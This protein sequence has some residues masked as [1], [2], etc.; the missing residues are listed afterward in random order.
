V[1]VATTLTPGSGILPA[2]TVPCISPPAAAGAPPAGAGVDCAH[3]GARRRPP[4]K[5]ESRDRRGIRPVFLFL[6]TNLRPHFPQGGLFSVLRR[7]I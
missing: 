1:L 3:A 7:L 4:N 5:H 6:Y 2:F